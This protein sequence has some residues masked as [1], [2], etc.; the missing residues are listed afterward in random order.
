MRAV[1][2]VALLPAC[3]FAAYAP[4]ARPMPMET[5]SAPDVGKTDGQ[6]AVSGD[7]A[8]WGFATNNADAGIRH[9]VSPE[10]ALT[11]DASTYYVKG[12][13][14][15]PVDRMAYTGRVGFEMHTDS[16]RRGH[17]AVTGGA[18]AG[19]SSEAGRWV[20]YDAGVATSGDL[21]HVSPF[22]S[23]EIF[24]S[25]PIDGWDFAFQDA[26]GQHVLHLQRTGGYRFALGLDC[27]R[28]YGRGKTS[29][30]LALGAGQV[31]NPDDEDGYVSFGAA[32]RVKLN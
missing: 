7:G 25:T 10:L 16:N 29:F 15:A 24:E 9:G 23:A 22:A 4:P 14:T 31:E 28:D 6:L 30:V 5:G 26:D 12:S 17:L 32:L 21:K 13:T 3:D 11:A 27:H 8:M 18:G 1:L 20:T 19:T 2:L